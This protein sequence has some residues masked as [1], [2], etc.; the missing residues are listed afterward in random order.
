MSV[1]NGHIRVIKNPDLIS[2][3]MCEFGSNYL[4]M[5]GMSQIVIAFQDGFLIMRQ[6]MYS[7]TSWKAHK[8][9]CIGVS[10]C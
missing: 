2:S 6:T 9:A 10:V 8:W 5:D 4:T 1:L 3:G 7:A